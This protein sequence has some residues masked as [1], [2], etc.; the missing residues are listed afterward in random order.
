[1]NDTE[2]SVDVQ[3]PG[4]PDTTEIDSLVATDP[5][6][7]ALLLRSDTGCPKRP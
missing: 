1:M 6:L 4:V 2:R 3:A 7:I 5:Y